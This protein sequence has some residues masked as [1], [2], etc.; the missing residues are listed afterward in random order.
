M[1]NVAQKS[2]SRIIWPA[3]QSPASARVFTHNSVDIKASPQQVWSLLIDCVAWPRWYE[4]CSDVSVLNSGTALQAG[5]RFRFK[6]LGRYFEPE[7]VTFEPCR[8]L[9][10]SA[11]GPA[12][13]SGSHAWYV[14]PTATGCQVIT[15]EAQKGLLLLLLGP[16]IRAELL[17]LHE[18]WVQS[19]KKLAEAS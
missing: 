16:R 8:M 10:W 11:K 15:E 5:A 2:D 12:G 19:L 9:V 18:D 17:A 4:H 1:Q 13:T 3:G 6:T 14:E 7:V